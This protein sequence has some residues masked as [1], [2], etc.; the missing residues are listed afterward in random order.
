MSS[1]VHKEFKGTGADAAAVSLRFGDDTTVTLTT[2]SEMGPW[3]RTELLTGHHDGGVEEGKETAIVKVA[4]TR[5]VCTREFTGPTSPDR[6]PPKAAPVDEASSATYEFVTTGWCS[7]TLTAT[8]GVDVV[9][10][11]AM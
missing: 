6:D 9:L 5:R 10:E 8:D 4:M 1:I 7:A 11:A 2:V 3:R